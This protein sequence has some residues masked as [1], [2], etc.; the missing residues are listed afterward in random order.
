MG[1]KR[2]NSSA[3]FTLPFFEKINSTMFV[4]DKQAGN[5]Q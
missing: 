5:M 3:Q 4:T 1:K 2:I